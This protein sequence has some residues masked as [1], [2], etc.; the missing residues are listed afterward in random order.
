M[1]LTTLIVFAKPNRMG[2]SKTRLARDIGPSAAHRINTMA[3]A[4]VFREV[5]DPRWQ[6]R[7]YLTPDKAL[8]DRHPG[9]PEGAELWL[10]SPGD[11]GTRLTVAFD[12]A[13][14]GNVIFI[15]TD[16]PDLRRTDIAATINS[17]NT[18]PL[19]VGPAMDGG[20]W[21]MGLRKRIGSHAPFDEVRWSSA[22]TLSDVLRNV[23]GER[24]EWLDKRIDL[25]DGPSLKE[26]LER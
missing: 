20:F 8:F 1:T 13:P 9:F 23:E 19:V 4:R 15:G 16:M 11:L 12:E 14:L 7:L 10:Q 25:D 2:L 26:W 5:M 21:L 18:A 3:Q 22:H 6:T 17:L 24:A